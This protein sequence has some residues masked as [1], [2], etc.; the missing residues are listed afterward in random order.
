MNGTIV[1]AVLVTFLVLTSLVLYKQRFFTLL[2]AVGA[3]RQKE[4][5]KKTKAKTEPPLRTLTTGQLNALIKLSFE[6]LERYLK[7]P[8]VDGSPE[9]LLRE[10]EVTDEGIAA[11]TEQRAEENLAICFT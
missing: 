3:L 7:E 11:E 10:G 8:R 5:A 4:Q 2:L 9:M 6:H 1:I